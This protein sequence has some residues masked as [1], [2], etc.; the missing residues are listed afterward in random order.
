MGRTLAYTILLVV[1]TACA[2]P[3]AEDVHIVGHAG[4]GSDPE[5]MPNSTEAVMSALVLGVQGV[6]LDVQMSADGVLVAFHDKALETSTSCTGIVNLLP[7][8]SLQECERKFRGAGVV[9]LD[10]LL[11]LAAAHSPNADFTLD[12]KLFAAGDWWS[13]LETYTDALLQLEQIPA[14]KG[15]LLVEC[16]VDP[17]L[18]L[19]GTKQSRIP[20]FRYTRNAEE[21]IPLALEYG[22]TGITMHYARITRE[23]VALAKGVGLEVTL[24]GAGNW[25]S[26]WR[27][28]R[29]EPDRLQSDAPELLMK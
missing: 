1:L 28:L 4:M 6:E 20:R 24:F 15:R 16:Q 14:L 22:Y 25:W 3:S 12:C 2:P 10:S 9:R 8:Q 21:T 13:Y 26:H 27:A 19:L 11:V 7:W 5:R 18:Q 29:K 17:F 23:Q